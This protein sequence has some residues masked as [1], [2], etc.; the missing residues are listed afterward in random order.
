MRNQLEH[1]Q[2]TIYQVLIMLNYED[3]GKTPFLIAG[4]CVIESEELVIEVVEQL[5]ELTKKLKLNFVF[6]A[7]FDK[8]NRTSLNSFRVLA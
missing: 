5:I 7:S 4:P 2:N 8:A 3:F 6:K 1:F